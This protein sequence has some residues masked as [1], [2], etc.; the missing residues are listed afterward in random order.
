MAKKRATKMP[1]AKQET[2]LVP[3]RFMMPSK[4]YEELARQAEKDGKQ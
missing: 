3:V 4:A 1:A 2:K